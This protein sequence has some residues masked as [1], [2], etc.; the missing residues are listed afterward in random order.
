MDKRRL[1]RRDLGTNQQRLCTQSLLR[2]SLFTV[3]IISTCV[4]FSMQH[5]QFQRAWQL[6]N[7]N[8]SVSVPRKPVQMTLNRPE[9]GWSANVSTVRMEAEN[10]R[11]SEEGKIGERQIVFEA[12]KIE[13]KEDQVIR[14]E[15]ISYTHKISEKKIGEGKKT[16]GQ[17]AE[18]SSIPKVALMFIA[19]GVVHNELCS[20][21]CTGGRVPRWSGCFSR[22]SIWSGSGG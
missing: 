2:I 7:S 9:G 12:S 13:R 6:L 3:I 4:L 16:R 18:S 17:V 1:S 11:E 22:C 5:A 20:A 15:S 21:C 14:E 8:S 19:K 10:E